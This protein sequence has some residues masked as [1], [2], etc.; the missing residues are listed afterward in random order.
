MGVCLLISQNYRKETVY[1][2]EAA[3]LHIAEEHPEI[4]LFQMEAALRYPSEVRKSSYREDSELH[5]LPLDKHYYIC[6]VVKQC[7]DGW[8]VATALTVTQPKTGRLIFRR[9]A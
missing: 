2:S 5:Y 9:G 8:Y 7:E 4:S 1:I 6:V 3:L